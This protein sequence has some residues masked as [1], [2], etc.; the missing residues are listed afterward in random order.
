MKLLLRRSC[1]W[2]LLLLLLI[3]STPGC[4]GWIDRFKKD[5]VA[6]VNMIV[7]GLQTVIN[8]VDVTFKELAPK[9]T[10]EQ[11]AA[12]QTRLDSLVMAAQHANNAL[13]DILDA[14]VALKQ[15]NPDLKAALAAA[16][17]AAEDLWNFAMDA[18][19]VAYP[20]RAGITL[21]GSTPPHVDAYVEQLR[22]AVE[23]VRRQR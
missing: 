6:Q 7:T 9:L 17:K 19:E 1:V 21:A 3:F 15:E 13:Y 22:F 18:K 20:S 5:P 10:A 16:G 11:R 8:I 2:L 14:A 12:L 4:A 23:R